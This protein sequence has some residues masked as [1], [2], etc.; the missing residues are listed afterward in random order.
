MAVYGWKQKLAFIAF[1]CYK[2]CYSRTRAK[3][4]DIHHSFHTTNNSCNEGGTNFYCYLLAE[5]CLLHGMRTW[6]AQS[7]PC[8]RVFPGRFSGGLRD[9]QYW[10]CTRA[11]GIRSFKPWEQLPGFPHQERRISKI[12]RVQLNKQGKRNLPAYRAALLGSLGHV[13]VNGESSGF[14]A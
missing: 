2:I 5:A 4:I 1:V 12:S 11:F 9:A 14:P 8:S 3:Q 7:C 6:A 13:L 10:G